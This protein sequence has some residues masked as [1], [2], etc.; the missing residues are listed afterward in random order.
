MRFYRVLPNYCNSTISS[1]AKKYDNKSTRPLSNKK[2]RMNRVSNS[3][4]FFFFI[5]TYCTY[6]FY[7]RN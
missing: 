7:Q 4:D 5:H 3:F 1:M 2:K 6:T